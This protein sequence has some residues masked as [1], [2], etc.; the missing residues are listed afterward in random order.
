MISEIFGMQAINHHG[1]IKP[2]PGEPGNDV[3][4]A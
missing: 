1:S 3:I 4:D 2:K